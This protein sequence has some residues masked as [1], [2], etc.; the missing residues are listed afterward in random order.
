MKNFTRVFACI[1]AFGCAAVMSQQSVA[2]TKTANSFGVTVEAKSIKGFT[3]PA[4]GQRVAC[5]GSGKTYKTPGSVSIYTLEYQVGLR[6]TLNGVKVGYSLQSGWVQGEAS[7]TMP[8]Y[9]YPV[10]VT[11]DY[12]VSNFG[13]SRDVVSQG[14]FSSAY[15][16]AKCS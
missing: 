2:E 7:A 8:N 14:H 4:D 11:G 10:G 6:A 13:R 9:V 1:G 12:M 5:S 15:V 16:V 3:S